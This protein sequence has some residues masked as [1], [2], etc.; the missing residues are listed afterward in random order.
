MALQAESQR[1]GTDPK[2]Y[3]S[4]LQFRTSGGLAAVWAPEN[5]RD[6]IFAA[7]KRRE[8]YATSGPRIALRFCAGWGFDES[9]ASERDQVA[10]AIAGGVPMGGVLRPTEGDTASPTFSW[11]RSATG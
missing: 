9:I 8:V 5:T 10:I 4:M 1:R 11:R 7:M 3:E 6:A 2:P